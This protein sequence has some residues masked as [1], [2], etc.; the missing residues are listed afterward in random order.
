MTQQITV[1]V[2]KL[3]FDLQNPRYPVQNSDREEME[4]ILLSNMGKSIRLAEHI[5]EFG[6]NPIDLIAVVQSD[7]RYIVLEGNRRAAVLKVLNKPLLLDSMPAGPGVPA[8]CKRMKKLAEKASGTDIN[9]VTVVLFPSREKADVW[10]NLKH[11]GENGGAGTVPWDA[12]AQA[13]YSNKGDIGL[14]LL[15]FGKANNWFTDDDLK[16]PGGTPFP[17]STL[18]RLLG[19]PDVRTALGLALSNNIL[20]ATVLADELGKGIRHVVNDLATGKWNVTKLKLKG[21]RKKYVA[22]L[23]TS[24]KP[25]TTSSTSPW[26]IDVDTVVP[27]QPVLPPAGPKPRTPSTTRKTLIPRDFAINTNPACP[28][29]GK[30]F[31]ELRKLEVDKHENAVAVL[32]RTYIELSLDDY[33][34]RTGLKFTMSRPPQATLAEKA[35]GAAADLKAKGLLDKNQEQNVH[36]LVGIN[37]DP[38]TFPGSI[39][40]LHA[41]VH[42][43]HANPISSELKTAWDNVGPF[44]KLIANV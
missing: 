38:K 17:L 40:T 33:I 14:E 28:R 22:Q 43:M 16:G 31:A 7:S 1:P 20:L 13:R 3:D 32:L 26:Q 24:A 30:M 19:D 34:A 10:I 36:R 18:N 6:Q 37:S 5:I 2:T 35:K 29:L 23:P 9:K 12:S 8:F 39:T 11:T 25:N 44:I 27:P 42:S 41:F 15:D 4:K 21:D